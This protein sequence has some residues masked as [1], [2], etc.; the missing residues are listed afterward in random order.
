MTKNHSPLLLIKQSGVELHL[1]T[2]SFLRS[3][4]RISRYKCPSQKIHMFNV[5]RNIKLGQITITFI[6]FFKICCNYLHLWS[7]TSISYHHYMILCSRTDTNPFKLVIFSYA[8]VLNCQQHSWHDPK[9]ATHKLAKI[10]SKNYTKDLIFLNY[11]HYKYSSIMLNFTIPM[12]YIASI[13]AARSMT[14]H[15]RACT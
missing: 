14:S 9:S 7:A 1:P 11:V 15:E 5:P 6:T 2:N 10:R 4:S 12:S 8:G 13:N 3:M